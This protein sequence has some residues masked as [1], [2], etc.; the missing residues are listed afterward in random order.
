MDEEVVEHADRGD[1]SE[2]G[3][4]DQ[5]FVGEEDVA[6][7]GSGFGLEEV[8]AGNVMLIHVRGNLGHDDRRRDRS[9]HGCGRLLENTQT[10]RE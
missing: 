7:G 2:D 10:T 9:R 5:P 1:E 6:N 3:G 8:V 4:T